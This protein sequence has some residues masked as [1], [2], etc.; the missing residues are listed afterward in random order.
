MYTIYSG[1]TRVNFG[2]YSMIKSP[3][4]SKEILADAIGKKKVRVAR[5]ARKD[6]RDWFAWGAGEV[7]EAILK[8]PKEC[9][10]DTQRKRS[11]PEIMVDLYRANDINGEDIYTHFYMEDGWLIID[12]FKGR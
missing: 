10:Y 12:S 6:A 3:Y 5:R 1:L 9:C 4:Y 11:N 2:E 7:C 8:L